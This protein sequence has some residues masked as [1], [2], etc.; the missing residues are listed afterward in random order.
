MRDRY[1]KLALEVARGVGA[2]VVDTQAAMEALLRWRG[3]DRLAPDGV[4]PTL[5][6]HMVLASAW[7]RAVNGIGS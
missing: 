4:H 2:V 6:G 7:L 5:V 1:A 3:R